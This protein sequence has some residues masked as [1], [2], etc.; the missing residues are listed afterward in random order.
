MLASQETSNS[1][2]LQEANP[3]TL[4]AHLLSQNEAKTKARSKNQDSLQCRQTNSSRSVDLSIRTNTD[5]S[6]QRSDLL[7][8]PEPS[9]IL[10]KG[11]PRQYPQLG[12]T[13]GLSASPNFLAPVF[14]IELYHA[15]SVI[16]LW[17][18]LS[19]SSVSI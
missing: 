5:P 15:T 14:S 7:E 16:G 13:L 4:A 12:G 17:V 19:G 8:L 9:G 2:Q 3:Q 18:H 6:Q 10:V 1:S 11:P